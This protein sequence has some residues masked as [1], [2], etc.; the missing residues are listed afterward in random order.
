MD[1]DLF[2]AFESGATVEAD[3]V[4]PTRKRTAPSMDGARASDAAPPASRKKAAAEDDDDEGE[5]AAAS[6]SSIGGGDGGGG[7]SSGITIT[8]ERVMEWSGRSVLTFSAIPEGSQSG[9]AE[10]ADMN[11]LPDDPAKT[12]P[13]ELDPFQKQSIAYIERNESVL[14][15]AHTS[16]GKTVV[17]EYA[18]AR[19][20]KHSQRVIYTS[21]IK[22]LSNQKFRD[23]Q[24]E[25]GV[26]NVGLMTGDITINPTAIVLIMTTEILRSMLYRG[27]EVMREVAWVIYDEIHYMRDKE[28]GV[29][30]EESIILLPHKVRFVFLSATIPNS[31]QFVGWI[32][33][34]H[35]QPCHVVYTNYRPTPLQHYIFP[36]GGTGLHLV[37]DDKNV[38]REDNFQHAMS[39]LQAS[40]DESAVLGSGSGDKK[41]KGGKK[42]GDAG[43]GTSDLAKIVRL[44]MERAYDPVIVFSFAKRE[45]EAYALQMSKQDF[46]SEE[47]KE[48]VG[49]VFANAMASLSD[50]DKTLP[51]VENMLP[52]LKRGIGIH[53]GGLLP[54]L[55]EVIEIMFQEGLLKCLFATETFSIGLNMPAHTV[56]FTACRKFDGK[57]FRWLSAGEY[58]QMA[59]RAGRR[60]KDDRGIVIQMLDEKMDPT[61]CKAILYGQPDELYS[62]Y[63]VSYNML[64]NMLRV[65]G[66]DPHF[67][68]QS[69]FHQYQQ[70][71]GAPALDA[72]ADELAAE[73]AA[74]DCGPPAEVEQL[75]EHFLIGEQL[76]KVGREVTAIKMLPENCLPFLQPGRLVH[77]VVPPAAAEPGAATKEG[78]EAEEQDFGWGVVVDFRAPKDGSAPTSV[79]VLVPCLKAAPD[80][81]PKALPEP[82]GPGAAAVGAG[83]MRVVRV[84]LQA[85]RDLSAVRIYLPKELTL[86][87]SRASVS[88]TLGEV[89]RRLGTVPP[90]DPVKDMHCAGVGPLLERSE[91]LAQRLAASPVNAMAAGRALA[92]ARKHDLDE[93]V[94]ALRKAAKA[95]SAPIL[96]DTMRRMQRVLKRLGH[97]TS[98]GVIDT[99]GRVACEVNTADELL[100]TE[101][102]FDG[103]FLEQ[104][105]AETAALLSCLVFGE[106]RK[107][108]AAPKLR[109]SLATPFR[110]L[111]ETAKQLCAVM[112]EAKLDVDPE[113]YM[114]GINPDLMEVVYAWCTGARF[115]DVI[116]LTTTYEGTVIRVIRRLEELLRQLA[117]AAFVIGNVPL[118]E[119]FERCAASMRRDIVFAASLYL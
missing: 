22:A 6:S 59:G 7:V 19:S 75:R 98:G 58:I 33:K 84:A 66:A 112:V 39:V 115:I 74:I 25:F 8:S 27:S 103:T 87:A 101:L 68:V 117:S 18:V 23:M 20:I 99:K 67:L 42:G 37:V 79:E 106:K 3:E 108:D 9:G 116:K 40:T 73:S 12:Y 113:V 61:T 47:E 100:V 69:S 97:V 57:D 91:L 5:P 93:R 45:C 36:A 24:E 81:D 54:I 72:Q 94:K 32:A 50:D 111:T 26:D 60:G 1:L 76:A 105:E 118:R 104:P 85:L 82:V 44:V 43:D 38:F 11:K 16:A 15:S 34:L 28:R 52:L 96:R 102:V 83:E 62:S 13:F 4:V 14:V 56:V 63:H 89:S 53:H 10:D 119:K 92:Y 64:L 110:A 30:W 41:K 48:L 49:E 31:R 71:S 65:E 109:D 29:V 21:P 46:N 78:G 86:E 17:A 2:G 107:D 77:V 80:G 51:Q 70:E 90:L 55:K 95:A 35:H 88:K 114:T